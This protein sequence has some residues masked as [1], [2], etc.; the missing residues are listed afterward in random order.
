MMDDAATSGIVS[1]V[2]KN[3]SLLHLQSK[4]RSKSRFSLLLLEHGEQFLLDYGVVLQN[5]GQQFQGRLKCCSRSLVF[6]PTEPALPLMK[7][8]FRNVNGEIR[9]E[10]PGFIVVDC[11]VVVEM[12]SNARVA[13]HRTRPSE[14]TRFAFQPQHTSPEALREKAEALRLASKEVNAAAARDLLAQ[15]TAPLSR[16]KFELRHLVDYTENV[17]VQAPNVERVTPLLRQPG[18]VVVTTARVYFEPAALNNVGDA[19]ASAPFDRVVAVRKARHMMARRALELLIQGSDNK[20]DCLRLAFPDTSARDTCWD[21]LKLKIGRKCVDDTDVLIKARSAW[22]QKKIDNF[23]YLAVLNYLG[24]RSLHDL[25]QYPVF[26]W[27]LKDYDSPVLDFDDP[28]KTFRDLAKPIGALDKKRLAE[29]L[30]RF[31]A[32]APPPPRMRQGPG[33]VKP[34]AAGFQQQRQR[35]NLLSSDEKGVKSNGMSPPQQQYPPPGASS[36]KRMGSLVRSFVTDKLKVGRN[37]VP[38]M[39]SSQQS[40]PM[41]PNA[42]EFETD[43]DQMEFQDELFSSGS[44]QPDPRDAAFLYGTHYSTPGYVAFYLVRLAPEYVLCLQNGK[45]DAPDRMFTSV[46]RAWLSVLKNSTDLKELVPEF[47]DGDGGFLANSREVPLGTTQTGEKVGDA[48]LPSWASSP[49]DF[50]R[51]MRKA[52]ES[53]Y[54]SD[55]L[56]LW[57]DLIFGFRQFGDAANDALNLFHPMTYEDTVHDLLLPGGVP[58]RERLAVET[59]ID[60]F[61]QTPTRLFDRPHPR[62]TD[63]PSSDGVLRRQPETKPSARR[64]PPQQQQPQEPVPPPPSKVERPSLDAT[65]T[66]RT[67]PLDNQQQQQQQ[68]SVANRQRPG[69]MGMSPLDS[70][71][72]SPLDAS[73]LRTDAVERKLQLEKPALETQTSSGSSFFDPS[74]NPSEGSGSFSPRL[75]QQQ[76]SAEK[77]QREQRE[78]R[79]REQREQRE[80]EQREQQE[81]QQRKQEQLR[82]RQQPEERR[83]QVARAATSKKGAMP[84]TNVEPASR[85]LMRA[86]RDALTGVAYARGVV[87]STSRDGTLKLCTFEKPQAEGR[88]FAPRKTLASPSRTALTCVCLTPDG[89]Y[90]V[91]GSSDNLLLVFLV[92]SGGLCGSVEAHDAPVTAVASAFASTHDDYDVATAGLD[93]SVKVWRLSGGH[94]V[95]EPLLELYDHEAPALSVALRAKLVAAGAEDGAL[96]VWDARDVGNSDGPVGRALLDDAASSVAVQ[97]GPSGDT[98]FA[99]DRSGLVVEIAVYGDLL[100]TYK[101][102]DDIADVL[103]FDAR[104]DLS[105]PELLAGPIVLCA[106]SSGDL[107]ILDWS[108]RLRPTLL[109][110]H[111]G[112]NAAISALAAV[113]LTDPSKKTRGTTQDDD[114]DDLIESFVISAA[115]DCTLKAWDITRL[116]QDDDDDDLDDDDHLDDHLS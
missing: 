53:D 45:F 100:A 97:S 24:D 47:Y 69:G 46:S 75:H 19:A 88:W 116:S 77:V 96:L 7:L 74:E 67:S 62:R 80:R 20:K 34:Q 112:H 44:S 103:V 79:E 43:F 63:A 14:D 29:F 111:K 73:K 38:G 58:D 31:E 64:Q 110:Q 17:L 84:V 26:P 21:A 99:A 54:V 18:M 115:E 78:Q 90:A 39:S 95:R 49:S 32:M 51:T 68:K 13:P 40:S 92:A 94:L 42:G 28:E 65:P 98:V 48:R 2:S 59:Q 86:H 5:G 93:A 27:V 25:A 35:R 57:I 106:L 66:P 4:K 3:Y 52:L 113:T 16:A 37:L 33:P 82:S 85:S 30:E 72:V 23:S 22:Q 105:A 1:W 60:E 36:G 107:A 83:K 41:T 55:H 8:C 81:K 56:H 108:D 70:S 76:K 102:D 71:G 10:K 104:P 114:D 9:L 50:V 89:L 15:L 101:L 61:G 6:E 91:A 11:S 109:A 12:M 87:A